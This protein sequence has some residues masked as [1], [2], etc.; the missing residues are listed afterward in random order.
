MELFDLPYTTLVNRA[1]PK[2]AFDE[3]ASPKQR[4]LFTDLVSRI[5]W[6]HKLSPDTINLEG[7]DIKEIQIFEIELKA[8]KDIRTVLEII[9]KA[10]PYH[11]IFVVVFDGEV[12]ISLSAKHSNPGNEDRSVIDWTFVSDWFMPS[13]NNYTLAL[14]NGLDSVFHDLCIQISG[15]TRFTTKTLVELVEY[16]KTVH[17]ME[18]QIAGIKSKLAACRQFNET[19][20]LNLLLR[21][22]QT[23]LSELTDSA[24]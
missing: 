16:K 23:K 20:Q 15:D 4:R 3:Y 18:S 10:I 19:V 17:S 2:N 9:D 21:E 1:I 13:Q 7:R 8:G 6:T 12:Y 5:V 22:M 11:I 24:H 14:R